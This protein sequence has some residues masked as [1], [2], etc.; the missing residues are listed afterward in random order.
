VVAKI[1]VALGGRSAEEVV[2]G[3]VSTGAE[4]D[5]EQLTELVRRMVGRWGMSPAIG[6][7]AVLPRDG[8]VSPFAGG[9]ELSPETQK[10]VDHEMRR[11][12]GDAHEDVVT[13][14]KE[15]RERL[16]NLA[17][18]LL[19]HETLDEDDAYAAAGV[20]HAEPDLRTPL[21]PAA[22]S[23]SLPSRGEPE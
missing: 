21:F 17:Q 3:D 11:V 15:H 22:L 7:L 13:L 9:P 20:S 19:E 8:T 12:V 2:F 5:L 23:P 14:L 18:A 10:L 16:D 6:P 1:R 4:S